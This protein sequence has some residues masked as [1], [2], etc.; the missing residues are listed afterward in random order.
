MRDYSDI[1]NLQRPVSKKHKPMAIENRAAQFA[2]FAALNGYSDAIEETGRLTD[3]RQELS[4]DMANIINTRLI[5]AVA[6]KRL[7]T[8]FYFKADDNKEGGKYIACKG[9]IKKYDPYK[10]ILIMENKE[11]IPVNDIGNVIIEA[12][13]HLE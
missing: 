5:E 4:E 7:V 11:I 9:Y 8:I 10:D 1:I 2:P 13:S 12:D 6:R 3:A